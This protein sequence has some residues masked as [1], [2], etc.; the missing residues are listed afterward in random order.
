MA[1]KS[2]RNIIFGLIILAVGM[3]FMLRIA[4]A[5]ISSA[6]DTS[7]AKDII[8]SF[9]SYSTLFIYAVIVMVIILIPVY[10]YQRAGEKAAPK[11]SVEKKK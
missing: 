11:P 7:P 10:L 9:T 4:S 3:Y 2:T 5:Y 6:G 1:S 8:A